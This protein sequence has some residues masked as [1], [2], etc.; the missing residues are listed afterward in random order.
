MPRNRS[1][2]SRPQEGGNPTTPLQGSLVVDRETLSFGG[3]VDSTLDA[4]LITVTNGGPGNLAGVV[5]GDI[6]YQDGSGWLTAV[7][8]ASLGSYQVLVSVDP[9]GL[10]EGTYEATFPVSDTRAS[11]GPV[12]ITVTATITAEVSDP[13]IVLTPSALQFTAQRNSATTAEQTVQ[14]SNGGGGALDGLTIGTITYSSGSGWVNASLSGNTL[15]VSVTPGA[16]NGGNYTATIPIEDAGAGNTPQSVSISMTLFVVPSIINLSASSV[17]FDGQQGVAGPAGQQTITLTNAGQDTIDS[18]TL[19]STVYN[20]GSGWLTTKSVAMTPNVNNQTITLGCTTG[21]LTA[22]TYT[23]TFTVI[24]PFSSNTPQT[25]SVTLNVSPPSPVPSISLNPTSLSFLGLAGG[26]ATAAQTVTVSNSGS[27]VLAPSLGSTTYG[28]G[29][30][31]LAP[32]LN[33]STL[34]IVCDPSALSAGT[35][36]A[37]VGITDAAASNSPQTVSVTFSVASVPASLVL[38]TGSLTFNATEGGANPSNQTI[39][40][41]NGG[42]SALAGPATGSVTYGSGSGWLT[43]KTV[44]GSSSPYT[45]TVGLTTGALAAGTYTASFP[46]TDANATNSPQTVTVTFVVSAGQPPGNYPSPLYTPPTWLTFNPATNKFT[47]EPYASPDMDTYF[48][49]TVHSVNS[50]ATWTTALANC[51]DTDIIEITADFNVTSQA[52]LRNRGDSGWVMIRTSAHASMPPAGTRYNPTTHT[53]VRKITSTNNNTLLTCAQGARG[54]L[55]YGVSFEKASGRTFGLNLVVFRATTQ[56]QL[57]HV[58]SYIEMRQCGVRN[59]WSVGGSTDRRGIY[60]AATKVKIKDCYIDGH[61]EGGTDTQAILIGDTPGDIE[62]HNCFLEGGSENVMCG[63]I[64]NSL[65]AA[66]APAANVWVHQNYFFKRTAWLTGGAG[67]GDCVRKNFLELKAGEQWVIEGNINENH[68]GSTQTNDINMGAKPQTASEAGTLFVRN[69]LYRFN[70]H[71]YSAAPMAVHSVPNDNGHGTTNGTARMEICHNLWHAQAYPKGTSDR[72]AVA[73]TRGFPDCTF[74]HNVFD[75][76]SHTLIFSSNYP[77]GSGVGKVPNFTYRDNINYSRPQFG[78]FGMDGDGGDSSALNNACGVGLWTCR[79]N[80]QVNR[81]W[82]A[83]LSQ[84]QHN[85]K[86]AT[87]IATIA[88]VDSTNENYALSA[89]SPYKGIGTNGSDP[90]VD[91]TFLNVLTNGVV[92]GT[93]TP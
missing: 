80:I 42:G 37:T 14:I 60:L 70:K 20:Q 32:T 56:T 25:V 47:G 62:I 85:N 13:T 77:D 81:G 54:Y 87:T 58:P 67:A 21:A 59:L 28:S 66:V 34:S 53:A 79:N 71:R 61:T 93:P 45:L 63:G 92:A 30:G 29:S 46:V 19:G 17:S 91:M 48:T 6:T 88:F 74:H 24:S 57:S 55:F 78:A 51:V 9:T 4:Q 73:S 7:R 2:R 65:G 10:T 1:R 22:G 68:D 69:I 75:C 11:N 15:S 18:I 40:I 36:T 38:S 26:S 86:N 3:P 64:N 16:L 76:K 23:A 31:W 72:N 12:T 33:G 44:T 89:S 90:G 43:T 35:Y 8:I 5:V 82:D 39:T 83:T 84:A 41:N 49:G 50:Q 52:T 27:G